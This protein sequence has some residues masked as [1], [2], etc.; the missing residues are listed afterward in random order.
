[1]ASGTFTPYWRQICGSLDPYSFVF[2]V[3]AQIAGRRRSIAVVS[4]RASADLEGSLQGS[5][6]I[7]ACQ[8]IVTIFTDTI[9]HPAIRAELALATGYYM[10]KGE[11]NEYHLGLV[12]LPEN[13]D[14]YRQPRLEILPW[15]HASIIQFPFISACLLQGVGFDPHTGYCYQARPAPLGTV[16]RDT[17]VEW[18]MIVVD[19]TEL[20]K[21]RYGIVGFASAPMKWASSPEAILMQ[22]GVSITMANEPGGEFRVLDEIRPRV[23]MSAT[24]YMIKVPSPVLQEHE[25]MTKLLASVPLVEANA[26]EIIWPAG[27]DDVVA[28]PMGKLSLRTSNSLQEQTIRSLL[29]SSQFSM[30]PER[31]VL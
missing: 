23:V 31:N 6:L 29:V 19:I 12:E 10:G 14:G 22:R 2:F 16:Y 7:A 28:L 9:N 18:G 11:Q 4:S 21:V 13:P 8:R 20:D 27:L 15:D 3:V 24:E 30:I 5:P 25:N 1:M 17:S 26:L